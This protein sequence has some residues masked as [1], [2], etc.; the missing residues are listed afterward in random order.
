MSTLAEFC[1]AVHGRIGQ[2]PMCERMR[3]FVHL[4]TG[5]PYCAPAGSDLDGTLLQ[6]RLHLVVGTYDRHASAPRIHADVM[7][8][9]DDARERVNALPEVRHF[10]EREN[11]QI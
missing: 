6:S 9:I 2:T 1:A 5:T 10:V 8:A 11:L 7:E 3:L 4:L